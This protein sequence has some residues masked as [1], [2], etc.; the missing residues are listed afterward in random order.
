MKQAAKD[1]SILD[2]HAFDKKAVDSQYQ[3]LDTLIDYYQFREALEAGTR[4]DQ[5]GYQKALHKRYQLLPKV[6]EDL[7]NNPS[8]PHTGRSPSYVQAGIA[9]H[10]EYGN[11]LSLIVRPAYYDALDSGREH[12]EYGEL[13]MGQ[14]SLESYSGLSRINSI[15]FVSIQ[16]LNT[17]VTGLPGDTNSAW[18]AKGRIT[19]SQ[20]DLL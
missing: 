16:S 18:R 11:G 2:D 20:Y 10:K 6:P 17:N 1:I 7:P 13:I 19:I 15:D 4:E 14:L 8:S 5:K 3:I 12:V 9:S